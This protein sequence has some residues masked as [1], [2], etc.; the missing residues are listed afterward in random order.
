MTLQTISA[1]LTNNP[2]TLAA[3]CAF[4]V[5]LVAVCNL[6]KAVTE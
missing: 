4:G 1:V 6:A 2:G 3:L 5:F